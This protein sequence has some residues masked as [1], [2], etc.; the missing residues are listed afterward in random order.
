MVWVGSDSEMETFFAGNLDKVLVG[1]DTGSFK[2]LG[3]QLF[4]LVGNHVH[5][6]REF[7]DI[8]TLSSKIEDTDLGVRHTTVE[9]RFG[10]WLVLAVSV[11]SSGSSGHLDDC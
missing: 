2:G 6:E 5:A 9:S 8:G 10:I 3:T 11:A 7:V 1:A 4:V